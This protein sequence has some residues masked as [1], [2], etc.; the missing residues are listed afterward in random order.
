MH[1][2]PVLLL[3]IFA[4]H[5]DKWCCVDYWRSTDLLNYPVFDHYV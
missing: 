3:T 4:A 1:G 5:G 2:T